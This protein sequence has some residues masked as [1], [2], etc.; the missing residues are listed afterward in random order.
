M[1][2][3]YIS[4]HHAMFTCATIW[5]LLLLLVIHPLP[6]L[7]WPKFVASSD[8][9]RD[10]PAVNPRTQLYHESLFAV[11]RSLF[12]FGSSTQTEPDNRGAI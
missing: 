7:M 6:V 10:F 4:V 5:I 8:L 11:G 2:I 1:Y 12:A 3:W 9:P